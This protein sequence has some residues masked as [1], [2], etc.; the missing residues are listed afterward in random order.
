MLFEVLEC[1]YKEISIEKLA[2]GYSIK[3]YNNL[4]IYYDKN[5]I[6]EMEY[7]SISG[8]EDKKCLVSKTILYGVID[9][10]SRSREVDRAAL[11]SIVMQ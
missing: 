1:S 2:V 10:S 5:R 7:D 9:V 11:E 8:L 6:L 3:A 4:G